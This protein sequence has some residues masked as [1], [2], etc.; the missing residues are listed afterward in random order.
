MSFNPFEYVIISNEPIQTTLIKWSIW[1]TVILIFLL[2]FLYVIDKYSGSKIEGLSLEKLGE[3]LQLPPKYLDQT[4]GLFGID[5]PNPDYD[6]FR[7]G[8]QN[9]F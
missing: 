3:E 7:D 2:V 8:D 6:I 5:K 9:M 1:T 4:I